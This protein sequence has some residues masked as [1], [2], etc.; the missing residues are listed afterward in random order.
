MKAIQ[1]IGYKG[2]GKS[3]LARKLAKGLRD[4]G[5]TV[6]ILKHAHHDLS[7]KE[8]DA[9]QAAEASRYL[10]AAPSASVLHLPGGMSFLE[11]VPFLQASFLVVEGFK[12]VTAMPRIV[13]AKTAEDRKALATGLEIDFFEPTDWDSAKRIDALVAKVDEKGFLFPA[14]DCDRCGYPTCGGLTKA[15]LA[16]EKSIADCPPAKRT[17]RVTIN[18]RDVSL[19]PF[20]ASIL[21][22]AFAGFLGRL[23][24]I[25]PG[26]V[27]I[28]F[29]MEEHE[30]G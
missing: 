14:L 13:C 17:T 1:I 27:V 3:T 11:C 22:G 29:D 6:S 26:K 30:K 24:G 5:H 12:E 15:V 8:K 21:Q 25:E 28:T 10:I 9:M 4:R 18:D 20:V 16:G 2:S 7:L 19:S 23:K